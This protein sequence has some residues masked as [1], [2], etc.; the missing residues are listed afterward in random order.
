MTNSILESLIVWKKQ[1]RNWKIISFRSMLHRFFQRLTIDYNS[2]YITG[3]GADPVQLGIVNSFAHIAGSLISAPFGWLQDRYSLRKIFLVGVSFSLFMTAL[4]AFATNWIMIIPA[5][6]L[7]NIAMNIG[8]CLTICDVSVKDRDRSTCKG[9]CDGTFAAPSIIA[10]TLAAFI[11]TQF[12][13]L[14][15]EGIRPLY[16]I[17]LIAGII[18]FLYLIVNLT[19]I[20]RPNNIKESKGFFQ[21][22]REVFHNGQ[23][24]KSFVLF[25][26]VSSFSMGMVNPFIMLFAFEIKGADQFTLGLMTT[27][28]LLIQALFASTLGNWADKYGRKKVFYLAEPLYILSLILLVYAP[29]QLYLIFSSILG[30]FRLIVGYVSISPIQTELV[31]IEYRGRWRGILGT[32][33]GLI[34]IPAP[35]IGGLIWDAIGP[36]SLILAPIF[37]DLLLRIPLLSKIPEKNMK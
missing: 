11:I 7:S 21:D 34:S 15:V 10:P 3:L 5:M 33:S 4:Y 32:F 24:L 22:I 14:N 1:S 17:Q 19:E 31:P 18:L 6:I 26:I 16:F 2:I 13:G 20:T 30:G 9:L 36:S 35:I 25:T 23:S 12:G 27:A 29:S 8:S 28:S 37:I